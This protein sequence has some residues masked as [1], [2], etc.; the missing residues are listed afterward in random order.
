MAT[1]IDAAG[2]IINDDNLFVVEIDRIYFADGRYQYDLPVIIY[3][4]SDYSDMLDWFSCHG[5]Y[6]TLI[7]DCSWSEDDG[8][9]I[10]E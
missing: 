7:D 9:F 3:R 1:M 6:Q 8:R 4:W 10:R 5:K 2:T